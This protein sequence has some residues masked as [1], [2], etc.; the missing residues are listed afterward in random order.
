MLCSIF[1]DDLDQLFVLLLDPAALLD[2]LLLFLIKTILALRVI[3]PWNE[4]SNLYPVVLPKMLWSFSDSFAVLIDSPHQ[5][6]VLLCAPGLLWLIALAA[7]Q[8]CEHIKYLASFFV[9]HLHLQSLIL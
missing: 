7:L 5:E 3:P 8:L 6:L 4:A 2:G 1:S 9:A